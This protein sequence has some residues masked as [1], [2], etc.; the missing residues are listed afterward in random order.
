MQLS[1]LRLEIRQQLRDPTVESSLTT[2]LNQAMLELAAEFEFPTL[3]ITTPAALAVSP[4]TWLY[5]LSALTHPTITGF[6]YQKKLTLVTS[7]TVQQGFIIEHLHDL[8]FTDPT[9]SDTGDAVLR[10]AVDADQLGVYPLASDTLSVWC[11]R[12]PVDMSADSDQP[13]GLPEPYHW[14]VLVPYVI[15]RAFRLFPDYA[16]EAPAANTGALQRWTAILNQGLYGDGHAL[17]LLD[18]IKKSQSHEPQIRGPKLGANVG[19][20]GFWTRRWR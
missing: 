15:L 14:R 17:G 2:W 7:A 5:N 8:D 4:S 13:D 18:Y 1:D 9:H 12:R 10:I 20:G 16:F 6:V 11:Y 19:G 3:R